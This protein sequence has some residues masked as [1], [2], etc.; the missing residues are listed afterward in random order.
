MFRWLGGFAPGRPPAITP[1][2][3]RQ[4]REIDALAPEMEALDDVALKRLGR[5]LAGRGAVA[6]RAGAVRH[7]ECLP[8]CSGG[9][10][11]VHPVGF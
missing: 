5:S 6:R 11:P 3:W 10:Q 8:A 2:T 7:E 1:A 4:V 9:L